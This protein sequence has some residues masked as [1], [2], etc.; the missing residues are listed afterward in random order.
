MCD[1]MVRPR[2]YKVSSTAK[3]EQL[4]AELTSLLQALRRETE[5]NETM[6]GTSTNS[7][8][9]VHIPKSVV[10]FRM[11]RQRVL[12]RGLQVPAVKPI[13]SQAEVI[14]RELESS[15][16][17]EYTPESLPLLLHQFFTDRSYQLAMCKYQLML[18]W[19]RF[20][21]HSTV[22]DQL[23]PQY[24]VVLYLPLCERKDTHETSLLDFTSPREFS[25]M[26]G[27]VSDVP[28]HSVKLDDLRAPLQNLLSHYNI[29]YKTQAIKTLA[30]QMELLRM[31]THR[32]RSLFINQGMMDT[33]LQYGSTEAVDRKWGRKRHMA[34]R[35]GSDWIPHI[36]VKPKKDPWQQ[37][38]MSRL[39]DVRCVD[40]QLQI[41]CWSCE[42]TD[43]HRVT[44]MLKQHAEFLCELKSTE[45]LTVTSQLTTKTADIW[46]NIYNITHHSQACYYLNS[47]KVVSLLVAV[48]MFNSSVCVSTQNG[49]SGAELLGLGEDLEAGSDAARGAYLSLLYLR[50]ITIR[51]L[52]RTCLG[53]L[54]YLRSVERTLT[55]ETAG[56]RLA[57]GVLGSSTEESNW[58]NAARGDSGST[59]GLGSQQYI[60]NTPTDYKV[61]CTEFMEFPEVENLSD[62]YS[63]EGPYIHTQD[64]RGL[65]IVYDVAL[66]DL[67]ELESTLLLTASHYISKRRESSSGTVKS[68]EAPSSWARMD[69]DRVAVLL[70]IWA[71]EAAFLENKI[72]L[73]NCYFEAYQHVIDKEDRFSLAQVITDI[74]HRRPRLD[75]GTGYFIQSYRQEMVCLQSHQQLIK[76]VLN[77]QIDKQH[78]Y[79]ERIWRGEHRRSC[80][81]EYGF[82]INY[83]PKQLASV[84]GSS[85]ALKSVYVLELHPSL[86]LA[87]GLYRALEQAHSELC[88]LIGARSIAQRAR[89]EQRLLKRALHSWHSMA[90]PGASYSSQIQRDLFSDVFIED[91]VL[92][93][94]LALSV[95]RSADEQVRKQGRERQLFAMEMLSRILELVTLRHRIVESAFET[96]HLSQLYR[97]LAQEMGFDEYHLYVRPV[98]FE[99]AVQKEIPKQL[100]LFITALLQDSACVDRYSPSSL[101]LAI[102][103]LDESQIGKFSFHSE[104]AVLHLM[105][106]SSLENLQV[107]LACQVTQK[108]VLFGAVKQVSLCYWAEDSAG[109][110]FADAFIS[111]QLE[112]V[113]PRDEMLTS[114]LKRK[115]LM[116]TLM[117]DPDEVAKI[118]RKLILEFCHKLSMLGSQSCV[119]GQIIAVC[120]SLTSLLLQL[121]DIGH[122]HFIVGQANELHKDTRS[123]KGMQPNPRWKALVVVCGC[124]K[125]KLQFVFRCFQPRPR[126]LLSADGKTLVN[127]WFIPHYTDVLTMFK[128]LEEKA[129]CQAL[130]HTLKI[131]SALHDIVFYLVNHASLGNPKHSLN[132]SRDLTLTADWGGPESIRAELWAVQQQVDALSESGSVEV[133][134]QFLHLRREVLLLG[135]HMAIHCTIRC[136]LEDPRGHKETF[137][138]SGNVEAYQSVSDNMSHALPVLSDSL[139]QGLSHLP[140]PQPLEPS[141]PETQRIYPWRSFIACHGFHPLAIW[142]ILPV[143]FCMQLCLCGL[144]ERSRMEANGAVLGVSLLLDDVLSN[145]RDAAPLQLQGQADPDISV[146]FDTQVQDTA[147]GAE[148]VSRHPEQLKTEG[149]SPIQSLAQQKSFLLLWKQ[150][151]VFKE[152]WAWHHLGV[153]QLNTAA[154]FKRVSRLY[155]MEI[156]WPSMQVLA[157]QMGR[158][159]EYE[160][161]L[162]HNESFQPPTGAPEVDVKT[163]QLLR[164]LESTECDMIRAVQRRI[165]REITLAMS[166]RARHDTALP[167]E[168]WKRASM[169]HCF[170]LER[171]Q[172]V[173]NFIQHLMGGA[174][175]T[176]GQVAFSLAHLQECLA[177]LGCAVMARERSTF[178]LYSQFYEHLLQ[179]QGQ[180]LHQREQD[181]KELEATA[182][183][184]NKPYSK[185]AEVCRA[186]MSELA[187]LRLRVAQLEDEQKGLQRQ[188]DLEHRCR[189]DSL[190]RQVFSMCM[191]LKARE[192]PLDEY[193]M[194]M[195]QDV[196]QL[197]SRVR[198]EGMDKMSKLRAKFSSSD[199][200]KNTLTVML[201]EKAIL[202]DLY[203]ENSQL[204]ALLCKLRT[205]H[206]WKHTVG[207]AKLENELLHFKQ[208]EMSCKMES[209]RVKIISEEEQIVLKQELEAVKATMLDYKAEFEHIQRQIVKQTQ[210]LR[211]VEHQ[212]TQEA[213]SRQE[214]E[215]FRRVSVERLQEE[216]EHRNAE[217][218]AL[219][220]QLD[221]TSMES[222]LQQQRTHKQIKQVQRQLT[223]ERCLKMEAFQTVDK[224]HNHIHS[225]EAAQSKHTTPSGALYFLSSFWIDIVEFETRV[226]F[227]LFSPKV[228]KTVSSSR[229]SSNKKSSDVGKKRLLTTTQVNS[230]MDSTSEDSDTDPKLT[231]MRKDT[232]MLL[233]RPKA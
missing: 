110:R 104:E 71:C 205:F 159:Q 7:Y 78:Q 12:Q 99:F 209:L 132:S 218:R 37:K 57:G 114:Y 155:R 204:S 72:E 186:L 116:P 73:L 156:Y 56:L 200:D 105:N 135:F 210:Q 43:V 179:Q 86:G 5:N 62:F 97:S 131:I 119:R 199:N 125:V 161:L 74:M 143:E 40:E 103:E 121:P 76:S 47:V 46:R 208:H 87:S 228:C 230:F 182:L 13:V 193:H 24:K 168:L 32:F 118:K 44:E 175:E 136:A 188:A 130:H 147:Y 4:E 14:Q 42:E 144:D 196:R 212:S 219:S 54:N 194:R 207:Q 108:N 233:Q 151:E 20:G 198:S 98:Q 102:Q 58:M 48:V 127:L 183:Q 149:C 79:L 67:K 221:R 112:K 36:Q 140:V 203:S 120:H 124:P 154:L 201:S 101:P 215:G 15:L 231:R 3:V 177:E 190:L 220:A 107:V 22:L 41:Y 184:A 88:Q 137:L 115:E 81:Y 133:V 176:E 17:L 222:Q 35:K 162:S 6:H 111:I 223:R 185:V 69:V 80:P 77:H 60:Y 85:L 153:E 216:V 126:Q 172:I 94:E 146:E 195:D 211:D 16:Q 23:Y 82:P 232:Q 142:D 160:V 30:D 31:V 89:L 109:G 224:L 134:E 158:E 226:T 169:Q 91:P 61:H 174:K 202:E 2:V 192:R 178:L 70:D 100:P 90:T 84:G 170:S 21:R 213:Q 27:S 83:T 217:I 145:E 52:K 51:E 138:T 63:T 141:C 95:L 197:V 157:Q 191:Q 25:G 180:L 18:R 229:A 227:L 106:Q 122:T 59:G 9:S 19:K 152:N 53:M 181:V 148:T 65:Y 113:G 39:K 10:Y 75:L 8:S 123:E 92:V 68:H 189:Y 166:E 117:S 29:Q 225:I 171:P 49:S 206:H 45:L 139:K 28:L 93:R 38:Q 164:L 11:E 1:D 66:M 187:T 167:T 34:L 128:A 214:L 150:L 50:H 64:Q 96:E 33:F 129:C 163:L 26:S 55:V 165:S 173:E